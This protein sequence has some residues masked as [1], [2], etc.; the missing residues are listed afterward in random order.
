MA[1]RRS[2]F[3][4]SS[5]LTRCASDVVT[6]SRTPASISLRLTQVN[7]VWG[8]QPI[9]GAIDSTASQSEVFL[10][11]AHGPFAHFGGELVRLVHS[12]IF[13]KVGA[14]TKPGAIQYVGNLSNALSKAPYRA[15]GLVK[16][17]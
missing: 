14:S 13:S 11:H 6:P 15:L 5:S 1:R 9:L 12:S 8:T 16:I 7:S 10:H 3:S 4:R 2:L 17:D